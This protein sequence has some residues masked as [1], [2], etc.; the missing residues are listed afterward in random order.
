MKIEFSILSYYPMSTIQSI[1]IEFL[2]IGILF[3]NISTDEKRL[4]ITNNWKRVEAFDDELNIELFKALLNGM[5]NKVQNSIQFQFSRY[6]KKYI[7]ELRFSNIVELESDDFDKFIE[8]TKKMFLRYDFEK[9]KR[10]NSNEQL[11]YI[12]RMFKSTEVNFEKS[13]VIGTFKENVKYDYYIDKT[14]F[15]IFTFINKDLN[16]LIASAKAWAFTAKEMKEEFGIETIFVYDSD[17]GS[18]KFNILYKILSKYAFKIMH[19]NEVI[20]YI[21][22]EHKDVRNINFF[23]N[24]IV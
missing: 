13:T 22:K 7:N 5:K 21:E 17:I 14:G 4:E 2:H 15:K 10:I 23:E 16:R 6:I 3:H 24:D 9:S 18:E 20:G 19:V 11:N 8:E 1:D 12:K